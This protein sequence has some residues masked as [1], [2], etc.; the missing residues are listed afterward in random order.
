MTDFAVTS[1][2]EKIASPR[3]LARKARNL[4]RY[5]RRLAR[6]RN[7]S[8]NR[9]GAAA[10]VA[11]A[12]RKVRDAR[13]DFPH[14]A[15]IRLVRGNDVIVIGTR[16]SPAWSDNRRLARAISD[17]GWGSFRR[18]LAYKCQRYGRDLVRDW[19]V[20]PVDQRGEEHPGRWSSGDGLRS[21]RQT[22]RDL[23]GAVGRGTGTLA[24]DGRNPRPSGQR[25]VNSVINLPILM[26][27]PSP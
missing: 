7:G 6:C 9:A 21:W 2:G 1:D 8:A 24:G 5:Q 4:A 16:T 11:R 17:C 15:I 13:R 26:V 27:S 10:K 22:F 19:P 20:V 23:R 14:R 25:V 12:H 3:H 18:Q